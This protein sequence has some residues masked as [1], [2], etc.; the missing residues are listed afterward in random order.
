M[1]ANRKVGRYYAI[2]LSPEEKEEIIDLRKNG[3]SYDYICDWIGCT[4]RQA[5][6]AVNNSKKKEEK[7]ANH[8][9]S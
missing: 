4:K 8:A 6:D 3:M 9:C 2:K 5:Q 1:T 7:E